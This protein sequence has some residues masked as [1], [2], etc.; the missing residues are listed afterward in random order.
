MGI[1]LPSL[2]PDLDLIGMMTQEGK[3][4]YESPSGSLWKKAFEFQSMRRQS[5]RR[6]PK[7]KVGVKKN[8]G[9][10][11]WNKRPK[12]LMKKRVILEGS[13]KPLS[14]MEKK[15]KALQNLVPNGKSMELDGLFKETANYIVCLE[16]QVK[17]MQIMVKELSDSSE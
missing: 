5:M 11:G 14:G 10:I 16:M 9:V 6:R 15:V 1:S 8:I 17:V 3:G 7:K 13:R 12:I 2:L 4:M